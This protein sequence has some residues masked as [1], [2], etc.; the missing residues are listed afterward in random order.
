MAI[1]H[2]REPLQPSVGS[3]AGD[4]PQIHGDGLVHDLVLHVG[5]W[6]ERCTH[7]Q[8]DAGELEQVTPHV[9]YEHGVTITHDRAPKPHG[10]L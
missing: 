1:L 3:V 5:L 7:L 9:D 2:P 8:L 10:G 6:V 4:A